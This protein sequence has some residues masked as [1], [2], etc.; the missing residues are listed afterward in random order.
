M[1]ATHAGSVDAGP[2]PFYC[3]TWGAPF[4]RGDR[5]SNKWVETDDGK[6]SGVYISSLYLVH[7][8]IGDL[9]FCGSKQAA[10]SRP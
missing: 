3:W 5:I 7:G 6:G 1:E 4:P 8:D 9:P 2:R 10:A